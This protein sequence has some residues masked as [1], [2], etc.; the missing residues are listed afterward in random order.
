M[1]K[2][3]FFSV[4]LLGILS[5]SLMI[6]MS[7]MVIPPSVDISRVESN[8]PIAASN[9]LVGR[10]KFDGSYINEVSG[11]PSA[12]PYGG[13]TN[14]VSSGGVDGGYLHVTSGTDYV[15]IA[16]DNSYDLPVS[17]TIAFWFRQ[18]AP[19]NFLQDLI[20]K[21]TTSNYNFYIY[22]QL[23][24]GGANQGPIQAGYSN[25]GW[26]AVT[27]SNDLSHG[28]WHYVVYFKNATYHAYYLDAKLIYGTTDGA[29]AVTNNDPITLAG[30]NTVN[31]DFDDLR[32]YNYSLTESD[33]IN[34]YKT[35]FPIANFFVD[36]TSTV[37][38]S[39]ILFTDTTSGGLSPYNYYWQFDDGTTDP[40]KNPSHTFSYNGN[41]WVNLTVTDSRGN[42]SSKGMWIYI[43]DTSPNVSFTVNA[44]SILVGQAVQFTENVYA[45]DGVS[46]RQWEYNDGTLF[47]T[48]M[49]PTHHFYN[50]GNYV[51]NLT[52][53]DMD[54]SS[55]WYA[56]IIKVNA[57][58]IKD[59]FEP[60]DNFETAAVI[61]QTGLITNLTYCD[62]DWYKV[63]VKGNETLTVMLFESILSN[64]SLTLVWDNH[65]IINKNSSFAQGHTSLSVYCPLESLVYIR[66][67]METTSFV[68][69]NLSIV[70]S[71]GNGT[72]S[73]K[74][75]SSS[76][77]NSDDFTFGEIDGFPME[78]LIM[79]VI[80]VLFYTIRKKKSK[81][82]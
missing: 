11:K 42:I 44:S 15:N 29:N 22:R 58:C 17:F 65:G 34:E 50:P 64:V 78:F 49:N 48:N 5:A 7:F 80:G 13:G 51:V 76:E 61:T 33:I 56:M 38:G 39:S 4:L 16:D 71:P 74:D 31:T 75:G 47:E 1:K 77:N 20:R 24:D 69:Y 26:H 32:I 2:T 63:N 82:E 59:R 62:E 73:T 28:K 53:Y 67:T 46:S 36:K 12:T 10:W 19:Q 9:D 23:N 72:G 60:N 6:G 21:G 68:Y 3:A 18:Y 35:Y 66:I 30:G 14:L 43:T 27:N 8:T 57:T 45:Y 40:A 81:L 41:F 54:G 70:F 37:E 79:S 52:I 25:S 55:G